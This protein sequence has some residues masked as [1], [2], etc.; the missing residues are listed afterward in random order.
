MLPWQVTEI[1]VEGNNNC[2]A[3]THTLMSSLIFRFIH[4]IQY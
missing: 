4:G 2:Y 3:A 1:K